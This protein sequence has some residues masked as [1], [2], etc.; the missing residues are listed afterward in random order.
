MGSILIASLPSGLRLQHLERLANGS[1]SPLTASQASSVAQLPPLE[2]GM[3][4]GIARVSE[5]PIDVR[6]EIYRGEA[7]RPSQQMIDFVAGPK[8]CGKAVLMPTIEETRTSMK[9]EESR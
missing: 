7:R 2:P 9:S 5:R 8:R 1:S 4:N 6:H 3:P